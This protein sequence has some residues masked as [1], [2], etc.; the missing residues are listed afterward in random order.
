M[1][2]TC[3]V[4]G[5]NEL[6]YI[7]QIVW[8]IQT[9]KVHCILVNFSSEPIDRWKEY[10]KSDFVRLKLLVEMICSNLDIVKYHL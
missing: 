9:I 4:I 5:L 6:N 3:I 2:S 1:N 10:W 8:I 7:I